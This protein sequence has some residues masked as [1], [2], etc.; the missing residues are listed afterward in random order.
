MASFSF[1]LRS[2]D[3]GRKKSL[4]DQLDNDMQ[5][6]IKIFFSFS[7]TLL[8]LSSLPISLVFFSLEFLEIAT[9]NDDIKRHRQCYPLLPTT[10][11]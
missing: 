5:T 2:F 6:T 3:R 9:N 11:G 1:F 4:Y 10:K 8:R 7:F